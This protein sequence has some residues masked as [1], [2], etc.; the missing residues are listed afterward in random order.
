MRQRHGVTAVILVLAVC[1]GAILL[2]V[3]G[4]VVAV[5]WPELGAG[6]RAG[7]ADLR[8]EL[9]NTLYMVGAALVLSVPPGLLAAL[10]RTE[11]RAP[12]ILEDVA[13]LLSSL[14]SVTIGLGLFVL[15]IATSGWPFSRAAGIVALT[16][17][18]LPWMTAASIP[19]LR[20]VGESRRQA[21]L[22]LGASVWATVVRVVVPEAL[23]GLVAVA[24]VG[25]ARL[26][27]EAAALLFTAGVNAPARF[28]WSPWAPGAT[29]AIRLF[30]VGTESLH[31]DARAMAGAAGIV[32]L[33]FTL[34]LLGVAG[35]LQRYLRRRAG[36]VDGT[37]GRFG[38]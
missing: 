1:G 9:F 31:P 20:Q 17:M 6:F 14:P 35:A 24:A 32:L 19:V 15:L 33:L 28:S 10:W 2:L 23:P 25:A 13:S 22:A 3:A 26:V 30:R 11:E 34:V 21:S 16:A 27:G 38:R 7:P 4:E 8:P 12:R 5:G 36:I 29:L 37:E 18:N